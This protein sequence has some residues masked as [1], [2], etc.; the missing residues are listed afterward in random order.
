[1]EIFVAYGVVLEQRGVIECDSRVTLR[2]PTSGRSG[3]CPYFLL[4]EPKSS[5]DIEFK[6]VSY[7]WT[8]LRFATLLGGATASQHAV[9]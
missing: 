2:A 8:P 1:M 5:L 6:A 3:L 4:P 9:F 7:A